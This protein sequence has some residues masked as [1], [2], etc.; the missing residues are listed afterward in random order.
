MMSSSIIRIAIFACLAFCTLVYTQ[1]IGNGRLLVQVQNT[2]VTCG[3]ATVQWV[4]TGSAYDEMTHAISIAV[5]EAGNNDDSDDS[6][7]NKRNIEGFQLTEHKRTIKRR[8]ASKM[9]RLQARR[10]AVRIAGGSNIPL[11]VQS[12]TWTTVALAPGTYQLAVT[13]LN[14]GITVMSDPFNVVTGDSTTCL[15]TTSYQ[16]T[17]LPDS[18]STAPSTSQTNQSTNTSATNTAANTSAPQNSS[19]TTLPASSSV[20]ATS[21][22]S[23]D[24]QQQSQANTDQGSQGNQGSSNGGKI[25]AGVLVPILAIIGVI[26]FF[27][28]CRKRNMNESAERRQGWSEKA[29]TLLNRGSSKRSQTH[30]RNI[31]Q[32]TNVIHSAGLT[33]HNADIRNE[34][35]EAREGCTHEPRMQA[36]GEHWVDLATDTDARPISSDHMQDIVRISM[37]QSRDEPMD[38]SLPSTRTESVSTAASTLPPYLREVRSPAPSFGQDASGRPLVFAAG[39][40]RA[41]D[42]R[43]SS[44]TSTVMHDL[45]RNGSVTSNATVTVG[46]KD[47]TRD[48]TRNNSKNSIRRKPV[49]RISISPDQ[50]ETVQSPQAIVSDEHGPFADDKQVSPFEQVG[51]S[52]SQL[53]ST[54][55]LLQSAP[56]VQSHSSVGSGK[57]INHEQLQ[58]KLSGDEEILQTPKHSSRADVPESV[59]PSPMSLHESSPNLDQESRIPTLSSSRLRFESSNEDDVPGIAHPT[60]EQREAWKLSIQLQEEDRGFSVNFP[61]PP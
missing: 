54:K 24:S 11:S 44:Q 61:S 17:D 1:A 26:A 43:R 10:M 29:I 13:I 37:N 22:A 25:A 21:P 4:W 57:T 49:P 3:S 30:V 60:A 28:C 23:N 14:T 32:P 39:A 34:M 51:E 48:L 36:N 45:S 33:Q 46:R 12:W 7:F 47:S 2:V 58:E 55:T 19:S 31:S 40:K 59:H 15:G 41:E 38:T 50:V 9:Q 18:T 20:A 6:G 27:Y 53:L 5:V 52:S 56:P 8:S 16:S 35:V 42:D